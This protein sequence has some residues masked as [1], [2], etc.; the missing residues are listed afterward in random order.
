MIFNIL[1]LFP[2]FF[3]SP[4]KTGLTGKAVES[5]VIKVELVDIRNFSENKHRRCDD[6]PYGG[7]SGMVLTAPPV[8]RAIESVKKD[9]VPLFLTSPSGRVL[10]RDFIREFSGKEEIS[11]VCGNYEGVDQRIIDRYIDCEVSIGDYVLSG[12]E[13]AALVI[14]NALSRCLPGFMSNASSLEEESFEED[15]LEYP[16]YTRPGEIDGIS[17]PEVLL[18][19]NHEKI[20]LWRETQSIEKTKRVRPDLYSKYIEKITGD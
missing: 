10:D 11:I 3:E 8:F 12:G 20:R 13:F 5:G 2:E 1:T 17:V 19:G 15:L 14:V 6:Y 18:S 16:H 4:L 9:N 7:G